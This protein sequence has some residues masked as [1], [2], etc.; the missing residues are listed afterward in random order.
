M[1]I[2]DRDGRADSNSG[3][4]SKRRETAAECGHCASTLWDADPSRRSVRS[5]TSP[6]RVKGRS[7]ANIP[8]IGEV[9]AP[10]ADGRNS[11]SRFLA[12]M[13]GTTCYEFI[14]PHGRQRRAGVFSGPAGPAHWNVRW[15]FNGVRLRRRWLSGLRVIRQTHLPQGTFDCSSDEAHEYKERGVPPRGRA[16]GGL[17]SKARK[18]LLLTGTLMGG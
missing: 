13:L 8:T 2:H 9:T 14:Q 16:N 7:S 5:T 17:A 1:I 10:E 11:A 15:P 4:T 3:G 18:T 12:S 6:R